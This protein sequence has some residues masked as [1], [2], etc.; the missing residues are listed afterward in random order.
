M[1][2]NRQIVP[3]AYYHVSTRANR[4][5]MIFNTRIMKELFLNVLHE[6]KG[7]Y[8]FRVENFCI[9]GNHF[10]LLIRPDHDVSLSAI[11]QWV[12]SVFALRYNKRMGLTGHVWGERFF[13]VVLFSLM[14]YLRTFI[15]IDDNPSVAGLVNGTE[16][17]EFSGKWHEHEG[18]GTIVDAAD[19]LRELL[20]PGRHYKLLALEHLVT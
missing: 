16:P 20:F 8:S 19:M 4:G 15:Y 7:K 6:A 3:G 14:D 5:E 18:W 17:Y 1:R 10:H 2:K 13:S 11:M 9:M 12:N